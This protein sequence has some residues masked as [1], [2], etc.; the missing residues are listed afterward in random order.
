MMIATGVA[1]VFPTYLYQYP[2]CLHSAG[3]DSILGT[4]IVIYN[5]HAAKEHVH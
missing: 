5:V 4:Y 3:L 2:S 1:F